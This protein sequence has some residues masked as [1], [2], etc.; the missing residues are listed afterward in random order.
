MLI[1]VALCRTDST[2]TQIGLQGLGLF[3]QRARVVGTVYKA[4][5]YHV[6]FL[7]FY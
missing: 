6:S 1:A 4:K 7:Q 3:C 5:L 2:I